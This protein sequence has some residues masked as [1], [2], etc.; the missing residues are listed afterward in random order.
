LSGWSG[1]KQRVS[2]ALSSLSIGACTCLGEQACREDV[3]GATQ[4][5]RQ[6]GTD[7]PHTSLHISYPLGPWGQSVDHVETIL[8][9][10]P[11]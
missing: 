5:E 7:L 6:R 3:M 10:A 2:L 4:V 9:R 1:L 11:R 8:G